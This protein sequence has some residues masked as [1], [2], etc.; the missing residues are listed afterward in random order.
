MNVLARDK[1]LYDGHA[2]AAVAA[3]NP[4]VAEE[5]AQNRRNLRGGFDISGFQG[6][7]EDLSGNLMGQASGSGIAFTLQPSRIR[8]CRINGTST[9]FSSGEIKG[10]Y[11]TIKCGSSVTS[12]SFDVLFEH[13]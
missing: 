5:A 2:V 6:T 9:S 7:E 3:V 12:G 11:S 1:L 8:G 4:H 10:S 13:P